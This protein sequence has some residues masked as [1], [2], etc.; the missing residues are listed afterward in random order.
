MTNLNTKLASYP[1]QTLN[2]WK[3]EVAEKCHN[4]ASENDL[5]FYV[6]QSG[7][8]LASHLLIIGANPGGLGSYSKTNAANK[9]DRRTANDLGYDENQFLKN[10]KWKSSSINELFK[11]DKLRPMFEDAV[12]TNLVYFNTKSFSDLK[13]TATAK[14]AIEFCVNSNINL[15][16]ILKP[17][18]IILLGKDAMNGLA[19]VFEKPVEDI[20]TTEDKKTALIRQTSINGIPVYCIHHP[21]RNPKFNKGVN[22]ESKREMFESL[23]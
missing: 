2:D 16:N 20:L 13:N 18:N 17:H 23:L 5:D 14:K 10:P 4:F 22:Q 11:G 15:I 7:V 19:H 3:K 21:S 12:I 6:F 8:K 9:R 1:I